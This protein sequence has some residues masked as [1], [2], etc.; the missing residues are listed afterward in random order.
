[1]QKLCTKCSF[2]GIIIKQ[3]YITTNYI[4]ECHFLLCRNCAFLL[5]FERFSKCND[6][7]GDDV[8]GQFHMRDVIPLP[9]QSWI[10]KKIYNQVENKLSQNDVDIQ[11]DQYKIIALKISE[12]IMLKMELECQNGPL[13]VTAILLPT[14]LVLISLHVTV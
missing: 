2:N 7:S 6:L 10:A 14:Y 12:E 11:G 8:A 9:L 5:K 1:M 13:F 4:T 3:T